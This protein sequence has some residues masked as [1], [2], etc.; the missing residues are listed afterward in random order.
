M[1]AE[2]PRFVAGC[3]D[4]ATLVRSAANNYG[5][6]G[7]FGALEQFDGD[8]K[9]VHVDVQN[10]R[11]TR[12][13]LLIDRAMNCAE[14]SQFRHAPS[15]RPSPFLRQSVGVQ[16]RST[17]RTRGMPARSLVTPTLVQSGVSSRGCTAGTL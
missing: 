1:H 7:E 12:R 10:R 17:A 14:A 2:L 13:R 4:N 16:S 3:G 15:L 9:R 8:E 5:F 6:A 11:N